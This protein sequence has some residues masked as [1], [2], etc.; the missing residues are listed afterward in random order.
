MPGKPTSLSN[1]DDAAGRRETRVTDLQSNT[2][3]PKEL[4]AEPGAGKSDL[5]DLQRMAEAL[6]DSELRY[7]RLFETAK[8]GILILDADSGQISDVNPYLEDMLGYTHAEILGKALWEIGPFKDVAAS[9]AAFRQLQSKEYIRYENLPLETKGEQKKQV[10]FVCNVYLVDNKRVIQCNIRDITDRK[11]A[12]DDLRRANDELLG[13]VSELQRRDYEMKLLNRMND[14]LQTCTT[15]DEAYKVIALLG[16]ELFPAQSGCLASLRPWDQFLETVARWGD[17]AL[18]EALFSLEDCWA[19]RRGQPYEVVDPRA[20]LLCRHFVHEPSTGYLCV[21]LT[22]HGETLGLL[23]LIGGEEEHQAGR[24]RL[25]VTVGEAIK[26][27]LSN[28]RLRAKLREQAMI[29]PL[30][31]LSNRRY[32]EESL[33]KEL[34][35]VSRSKSALSAAMLDL[36]HFKAFNDTF[37][38][39]SGDLLLRE[40]GRV[41]REKLRKSDIAA[42]YGGEEFVLVLPDSSPA[43]TFQKVE[44]IR[45]MIRD[46]QIRHGDQ[47]L[48]SMTVS[49]GVAQAHEGSTARDLLREADEAMYAAKHAGRDRVVLYEAKPE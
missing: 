15:Q 34:H 49:A 6:R 22:V 41:L 48:S 30:T 12:A 5:A 31:G 18:P 9:Q 45:V 7:R 43:D 4:S 3:A 1:A 29:D 11:H 47:L 24:Q 23:S 40:V 32:L 35:R 28:L 16:R 42:R 19:M 44:E 46:L 27:C 8:D 10:E 25:A 13:V 26:L 38:H 21:P 2:R 20:S 17:D 39:D 36:D 37:G 33:P 14:L